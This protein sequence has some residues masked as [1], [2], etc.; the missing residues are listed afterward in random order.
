MESQEHKPL[1][2]KID[3]IRFAV[4]DLDAG[5]R[6]YQDQLG[7]EL[8]WRTENEAGLRMIDTSAEI[9]LHTGEGPP[10]IDFLVESAEAAAERFTKAGGRVIVPPFDIQIGRCVV[11]ADPWGNQLILLDTS[12]G[13]L[14]TDEDGNVI[15]T[16]PVE[17]ND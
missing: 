12:K 4:D 2:H 6:F 9:V 16:Q 8:I 15:G 13:L 17:D 7:H 14:V 3:C 5:L 10:E 1:M 11:V